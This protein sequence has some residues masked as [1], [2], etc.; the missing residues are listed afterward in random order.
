MTHFQRVIKYLALLLAFSLAAAIIIGGVGLMGAIFG[1]GNSSVLEEMYSIE[2]SQNIES[3]DIDLSAASLKIVL[4]DKF[5][6]STNIGNLKVTS[7]FT[8]KIKQKP[9]QIIS[10]HSGKSGE[11]ILT[12]P[13]DIMLKSFEL[14]AGAG[15]VELECLNAE[16]VEIDAGAGAITINGGEIERLDLD[17]GVGKA[18]ITSAIKGKSTIDCGVGETNINLLGKSEDYTLDIDTGIGSVTL[19]GTDIKGNTKIGNGS[20]KLEIDGG[21]GAININFVNE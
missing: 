14:D 19:N 3:V 9:H 20:N 7:D 4:G 6:L 21:V 12:V 16:N 8:L 11:I 10:I 1:M 5:A 15:Y 17:L 2:L 13:A 18:N